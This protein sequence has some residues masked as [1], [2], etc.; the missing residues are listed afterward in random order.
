MAYVNQEQATGD[1]PG[2]AKL[3]QHLS[4]LTLVSEM[5]PVWSLVSI[6]SPSVM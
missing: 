4:M 6:G 1:P 5:V 3:Y 2:I